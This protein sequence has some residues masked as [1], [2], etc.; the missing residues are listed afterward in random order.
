MGTL[1]EQE[2]DARI[3]QLPPLSAKV[4]E[5]MRLLETTAVDYGA[6]ERAAVHEPGLVQRVLRLA[7][8]SFYGVSGRIGTFR[9]ACLVLGSRSLR[10]VVMAIAVMDR[11]SAGHTIEQLRMLWQHVLAVAAVAR[12]L[13]PM[14]HVDPEHA[15]TAGLLH[16]IGKLAMT[17]YFPAEYA[18]VQQTSLRDGV[19][20][21]QIEQD[22]IGMDHGALGGKL[23]RR[24]RLPETIALV[25]E[26]HHRPTGDPVNP[27][28]DL[29]HFADVLAHA[30][31]FGLSEDEQVPP[32]EPAVWQ[33]LGWDWHTVSACLPALDRDAR[34]AGSLELS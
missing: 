18:A 14:A 23:A 28:I 22:I 33:R 10:Q 9:E 11:L 6:M 7:N 20:R 13:A 12:Y 24:W 16:D 32:L 21:I 30:L 8:S 27:L 29:L 1:S 2:I 31:E 3:G 26:Q 34:A 25:N 5:L 17:A 4:V 19:P 15:F